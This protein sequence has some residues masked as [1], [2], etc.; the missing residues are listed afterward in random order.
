MLIENG[1]AHHRGQADATGNTTPSEGLQRDAW[2][3]QNTGSSTRAPPQGYSRD[4]I[5]RI[6]MRPWL[7]QQRMLHAEPTPPATDI[8][9]ER[10]A[11]PPSEIDPTAKESILA[12][13]SIKHA[14]AH[15]TDLRKWPALVRAFLAPE[16]TLSIRLHFPLGTILR[17]VKIPKFPFLAASPRY[18]HTQVP[19]QGCL[20]LCSPDRRMSGR[21][22]G[23]QTGCE[24]SAPPQNEVLDMPIPD[25]SQS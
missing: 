7:P 23:L 21:S 8:S 2:G 15:G 11:S 17:E 13:T 9:T 10:A 3:P 6:H 16:V 1:E 22:S 4:D 25:P 18:C 14:L 20:V 12:Y 19:K 5:H 24:T